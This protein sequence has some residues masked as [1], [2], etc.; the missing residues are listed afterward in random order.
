MDLVY[1]ST[2]N[3]QEKVTASQA[4]LKGLAGEGGLFVP[5]Q[6]PALDVSMEELGEDELSGDSL[7]GDEAVSDGFYGG[8]VKG[9]HRKGLRQQI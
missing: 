3:A 5:T 1:V 9:L 7:R 4:I 8:R 2:R 6:I